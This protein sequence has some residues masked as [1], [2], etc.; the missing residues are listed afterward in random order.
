VHD[1]CVDG[2]AAG[3]LRGNLR[4]DV[5]APLRLAVVLDGATSV[6]YNDR[7]T[8]P[9]SASSSL[10]SRWAGSRTMPCAS[11]LSRPRLRKYMQLVTPLVT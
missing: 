7:L 9:A 11:G 8:P 4:E 10:L 1:L 3:L 5:Q 6:V 2:K